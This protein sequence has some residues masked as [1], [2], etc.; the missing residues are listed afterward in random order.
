[1]IYDTILAGLLALPAIAIAIFFLT[2]RT[3]RRGDRSSERTHA[4]P[5]FM[6]GKY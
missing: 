6:R 4:K 1:M 3:V 5:S 2:R